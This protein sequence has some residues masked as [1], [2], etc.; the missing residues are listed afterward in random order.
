MSNHVKS[1]FCG[2]SAGDSP[3]GCFHQVIAPHELL[4]LSWREVKRLVPNIP[5]GWFELSALSTQDRIGFV[6][7]Y[8]L[9]SLPFQPGLDVAL[10]RFFNSLGDIGLYLT[11]RTFDEPFEAHLVYALKKDGGFFQGLPPATEADL[12][13]LQK[14][15][16]DTVLPADYLAFIQIHNGFAKF[17]DTGILS[18]HRV[19]KFYKEFQ[20]DLLKKEPLLSALG[21]PINPKMLIP[22]YESFGFPCYQ[23]FWGEWYPAQ[24]MGNLYYSGLTHTVTDHR[25]G[26]ASPEN[27]SFPTFLDWLTFYL[28]G[29]ES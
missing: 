9:S 21:E 14:Q 16:G 8:W 4:E 12:V 2:A 26:N 27:Q 29:I 7:D 25:N 24:E 10:L 20:E 6:R 1:Y 28:E 13:S 18:S 3:R 23:C 17:T 5:K 15:F 11:Q 19:A 22:F